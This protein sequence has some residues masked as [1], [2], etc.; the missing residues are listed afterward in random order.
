M[1]RQAQRRVVQT[2]AEAVLGAPGLI[3]V[4]LQAAGL[5]LLQKAR[6]ELL[7]QVTVQHGTVGRVGVPGRVQDG[8]VMGFHYQIFPA[9]GV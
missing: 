1:H 9:P 5:R 2:A 7:V 4:A 6:H 3:G 8:F